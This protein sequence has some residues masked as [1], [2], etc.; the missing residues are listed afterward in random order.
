MLDEAER[1]V[2]FDLFD[3]SAWSIMIE[4]QCFFVECTDSYEFLIY[5]IHIAFG[6]RYRTARDNKQRLCSSVTIFKLVASTTSTGLV[7]SVIRFIRISFP[8][9]N[10]KECT[11]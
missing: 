3:W 11:G 5:I 4:F 8:G 10:Q 6:V 9:H 7:K 1:I 2:F